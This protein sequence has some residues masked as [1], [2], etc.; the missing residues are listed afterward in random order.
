MVRDRLAALGRAGSRFPSHVL[1]Q[2]A[3]DRG[4]QSERVRAAAAPLRARRD[5]RP[6]GRPPASRSACRARGLRPCGSARGIYRRPDRRLVADTRRRGLSHAD[7]RARVRAGSRVRAV[8]A[9]PA[10]G[11]GGLQPQGPGEGAGELLLQP[12]ASHGERHD[13]AKRQARA[14]RRLG[15]ARSRVVER[16]PGARGRRVG[17]DGPQSRRRRCAHGVPDSGQDGGC[18]LGGRRL[19]RRRRAH[20]RLRAGRRAVRA[21]APLAIAADRSRVPG[22]DADCGRGSASSSSSRCWT[23]RSSIHARAPALSTGRARS[24]RP[25]AAGASGAATWN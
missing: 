13:G 22:G 25:K 15:V 21:A 4:G 8:A 12:S 9:D 7:R 23:T 6:G 17:L 3:A 16:V 20:A 10:P 14:R 18:L 1:P 24:P 5:R 2:P 19:A 11:R